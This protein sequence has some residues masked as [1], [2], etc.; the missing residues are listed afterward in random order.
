MKE[1]ECKITC[2]G[3]VVAVIDC[4]KEGCNIKPTEAGKKLFKD[5]CKDCC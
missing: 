3:K 5:H 4:T 1:K 2:D